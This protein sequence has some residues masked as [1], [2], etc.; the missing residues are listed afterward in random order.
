MA[1]DKGEWPTAV[2]TV[3]KLWGS[4]KCGDFLD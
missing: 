2:N 1:V 4:L 3:M